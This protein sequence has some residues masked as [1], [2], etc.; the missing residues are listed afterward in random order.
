MNFFSII[1]LFGG[2]ALFL[3][4][5]SVL[6]SSL[7][8]AS[9]GRLERVLEQ[10][11]DS[12]PKAIIFGALVTGAIQSSSATTV[13]VVGLVNAKVL[14][15]RQAI[16]IIMGANI[17][18]T[19]TAHILRLSD[20]S[21]GNFLLNFIKPV[22][23]APLVAAIG[24][25]CYMAGK[26]E[27]IKEVGH[28]MLG[29]GVLFAGMF[30]M[31]AAMTPL[32]Q[33]P[34]FAQLF[35][36]MSN[37][38][39]GV[40]AGAAIT[41]LLQSSSASIGILQALSSTGSIACSAAF[42]VILGQ[43]IGTCITPI[44]ASVGATK[45]AKRAAFVHLCFN[46][47]GTAV[48]LAG[49]YAIQSTVGFSFW[50]D[51]ITKGGIANFH[52]LFNVGS[53]LLFLPFVS[54]LEKLAYRIIRDSP[55]E[56]S[57]AGVIDGLDER[58]L[59]SPGL[60]IEHGRA[61]VFQMAKL[62]LENY[63]IASAMAT[64]QYDPKA[65]ERLAFNEGCLDKLQDRVEDYAIKISRRHITEKNKEDVNELLHMIG[66]LERIGD[67]CENI[68]EAMGSQ[69]VAFS[70]RAGQEMTNLCGAVEEILTTS[71]DAYRT[72]NNMLAHRVEPLEQVIDILEEQLRVG[73]IARLRD[74][75][76]SVDGAFAFISAISAMERIADH[77]SNI[78]VFLIT[79]KERHQD[80]D[81][82]SYLHAL[83]RGSSPEYDRYY[84]EYR[85]KYL[86]AL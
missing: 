49:L 18:T 13:V 6:S 12:L 16:G 42:P 14:R 46:I 58:L 35:A 74:G 31:E 70:D 77:C 81:T 66:E 36:S 5:M 54:L 62:A 86:S 65:A 84:D 8:K 45:G 85:Q 44:L 4:G 19:I 52:T 3:F 40:L 75:N 71:I 50:N 55:G 43:N 67:Q 32:S 64:S 9:E 41:A 56:S 48:F 68:M 33:L 10:L 34:G 25:V 82:H 26:R 72:G 80:F 24:I 73:H 83:H 20:I 2:L 47:F 60:A 69:R 17:G 61:A 27:K 11:T 30:Q 57:L 23:L 39:L 21:S 79:V 63:S 78:A 29:F 7:E 76:C 53:T 51:P 38:V 37:P 15:L 28:I 1:S 22:N 59:V